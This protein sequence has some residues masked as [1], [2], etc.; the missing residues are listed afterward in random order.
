MLSRAQTQRQT[1]PKIAAI[2]ELI[3][4][5][6]V[7]KF[8]QLSREEIESMLGLSELKQTKVYQE[9]LDEGRQEGRQEGEQSGALREAQSLILRQL[10]RRIGDVSPELQSQIQSLSLDQLE[11]LGEALLDFTESSDLVN[12]LKEHYTD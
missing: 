12:W 2:M 1:N 3:E 9:A 8:P 7:Y 10:T 6:V 5:I 4:T 11:T